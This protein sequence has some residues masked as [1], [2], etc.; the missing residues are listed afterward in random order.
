MRQVLLVA[1]SAY[2]LGGVAIWLD[3]LLRELP[4]YG[5]EPT[6]GLVSGRWHD[7]ERYVG[8]YPY[9][10]Y[11]RID[12]PSGSAEGRRRAL[13]AAIRRHRPEIVVGVNIA[14]VYPACRRLRLQGEGWFRCV[15][16][17][18]GIV[19]DLMDDLERHRDVVEDVIATNRLTC[20]LCSEVAQVLRERVHYAPYGVDTSSL[21]TIQRERRTR[22]GNGIP[23]RI[24]YVGRLDY[25]QKRVDVLPDIL[26]HLDESGLDFRVEI[27]GEGPREGALRE[28]LAPWLASGRATMLGAVSSG[29]IG[30]VYARA[31]VLL[32]TSSWETG[33]IVIWEAMAVGVPVVT[34]RYVGCGLEGALEHGE[35]CLMFPVGDAREAARQL[36]KLED[37][38][39]VGTLVQAGRRLVDERY[40][41]PHSVAAWSRA[42]QEI[43][44]S[45]S[46]A[47]TSPECAP[48][49]AGRLDRLLGTGPAETVRRCLGIAF[50]HHSPGG[51]W[52]HTLS[53]GV[54]GDCFMEIAEQMDGA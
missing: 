36:T 35:N 33:P 38:K 42:L 23:L 32:V 10:P 13:A 41:I 16:A 11:I 27:A 39:V 46:A 47:D 25:A 19:A 52:P 34:S 31:D 1:P 40:S 8:V 4:A 7:V 6:V 2:P 17:L 51:E 26:G 18:H 29:N 12:N 28:A 49:P 45:G 9:L 53:R 48:R 21:G 15:M 22:K 20:R 24:V 14:D 5:W 37:P 54:D 44:A 43:A 50:A 30:E 3:Y